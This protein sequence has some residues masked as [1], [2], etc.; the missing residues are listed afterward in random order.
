MGM[1][2]MKKND[3]AGKLERGAERAIQ[4]L[5][6]LSVEELESLTGMKGR[7]VARLQ[8]ILNAGSIADLAIVLKEKTVSEVIAVLGQEREAKK[9]RW[10]AKYLKEEGNAKFGVLEGSD[11]AVLL[12]AKFEVASIDELAKEIKDMKIGDIVSKLKEMN[13]AG[14]IEKLR[15]F[16][17]IP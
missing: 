17:V 14:L 13:V 12:K 10:L 2:M 9:V 6:E 3:A 1:N 16:G 11:I 7:F 4:K 8:K 15:D 5:K